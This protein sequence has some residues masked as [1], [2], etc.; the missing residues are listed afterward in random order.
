M[1]GEVGQAFSAEQVVAGRFRVVRLLA[2]GGMGE[3]YEAQDLDLNERVAL[4]A[5]RSELY[6]SLA[7]L[8]GRASGT[9]E[10]K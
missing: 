10:P 2:R 4:K 3:V 1:T 6:I 8:L 5:I 9:G 7:P